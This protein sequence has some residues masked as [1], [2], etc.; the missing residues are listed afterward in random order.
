MEGLHQQARKQFDRSYFQPSPDVYQTIT[1]TPASDLALDFTYEESHES[2]NAAF[3]GVPSDRTDVIQPALKLMKFDKDHET[4][5][6]TKEHLLKAIELCEIE[7]YMLYL[8]SCWTRGFHYF[9]DDA[10]RLGFGCYY[11]NNGAF[12]LIWTHDIMRCSTKA[13]VVRRQ[14]FGSHEANNEFRQELCLYRSL[15]HDP[16]SLAF[17]SSYRLA[18]HVDKFTQEQQYAVCDVEKATTFS[19]W[20]LHREPTV[21]TK[22]IH[23]AEMSRMSQKMGAALIALAE[24]ARQSEVIR[25]VNYF[26]LSSQE[27]EWVSHLRP[28]LRTSAEKNRKSIREAVMILQSQIESEKL[29]IEYVQKRAQNQLGVV[30]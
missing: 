23:L 19:P 28:E 8:L 17:V 30:S 13:I 9:Q 5:Y 3:A 25:R 27:T 16:L 2:V 12:V 24:T 29:D 21:G 14:T 20:Y 11:I 18:S 1:I 4:F 6:A 15:A 10:S 26:I 22:R 7:P